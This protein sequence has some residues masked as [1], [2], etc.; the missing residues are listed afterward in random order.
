MNDRSTEARAGSTLPGRGGE[1]WRTAFD[2]WPN[3]DQRPFRPGDIIYVLCTKLIEGEVASPRAQPREEIV[4]TTLCEW[5]DRYR[6][7]LIIRVWA[8][9]MDVLP[10]R[11]H[12]DTGLTRVPEEEQHLYVAI[13]KVGHYTTE[14]HASPH[15]EA[16]RA[17]A[18]GG[19]RC[20]FMRHGFF[21]INMLELRSV[22]ITTALGRVAHSDEVSFTSFQALREQCIRDEWSRNP[23]AVPRVETNPAYNDIP[24]LRRPPGMVIRPH[25]GNHN[26]TSTPPQP[27]GR[28]NETPVSLLPPRLLIVEDQTT[29]SDHLAAAITSHSEARGSLETLTEAMGRQELSSERDTRAI[30]SS[31]GVP[32]AVSSTAEPFDVTTLTMRFSQFNRG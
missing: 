27:S 17:R 3:R 18:C 16:L 31:R 23:R 28:Q 4:A 6:Y 11:T 10:I 32:L 29:M 2:S 19:T 1:N 9:G 5:C 30:A 25:T 15:P 14:K 12:G 20:H 22:Q 26:G 21:Y 24:S 13:A 7:F 8:T